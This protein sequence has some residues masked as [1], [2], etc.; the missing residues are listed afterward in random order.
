MNGVDL[1]SKPFY[2]S[3]EDIKWVEETLAGMD[4]ETKVGQLFC[5]VAPTE[6]ME[7]LDETLKVIKPG[8]FM[9]RAFP[10]ATIQQNHRYL[11][12]KSEIPLLLAANLERGGNGIA[13]DGTHFGSPMQVA[14]TDDTNRVNDLSRFFVYDL[15]NG[16]FHT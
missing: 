16:I 14:A 11:Q 5:L 4:L 9:Y 3:D 8:G 7:T 10:G 13:S 1:K 6:D 12:E 15:H 2:L